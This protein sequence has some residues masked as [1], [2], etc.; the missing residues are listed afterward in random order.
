M[1]SE[2]LDTGN[3]L[4]EITIPGITRE[5]IERYAVVSGD[6]N[7]VHTDDLLARRLGLDG[8]PVQGMYVMALV[9]TYLEQWKHHHAV[10]KLHV[11]FVAPVLA[12]SDIKISAKVIAVR[13]VEQI[14]IVRIIVNQRDNL[15]AMG[16][17][18]IARSAD[19]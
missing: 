18:H 12:K 5:E 15:V 10:R 17:A 9:N 7:P 8:V 3:C 4:Q 6:N 19:R 1:N 16:E 11:R 14:A 13:K 2:P